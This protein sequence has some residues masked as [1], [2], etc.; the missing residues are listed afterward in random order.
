MCQVGILIDSLSLVDNAKMPTNGNAA[1]RTGRLRSKREFVLVASQ[2]SHAKNGQCS[3][4]SADQRCVHRPPFGQCR[5]FAKSSNRNKFLCIRR[6]FE[7]TLRTIE[8]SLEIRESLSSENGT[9]KSGTLGEKGSH[10]IPTGTDTPCIAY[11]IRSRVIFI[12]FKTTKRLPLLNTWNEI[13][14]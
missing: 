6:C 2:Q 14:A 9:G 5:K 1:K 13:P 3:G 10:I 12:D 4:K 8:R 7:T 11:I